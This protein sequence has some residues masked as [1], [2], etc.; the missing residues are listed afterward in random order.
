[1]GRNLRSWWG[2][3]VAMVLAVQPALAGDRKAAAGRE[4]RASAHQVVLPARVAVTADNQVRGGKIDRPGEVAFFPVRALEV[5]LV[6]ASYQASANEARRDKPSD[7][8]PERKSLTFFRLNPKFGDVSVQ[9]VF[10]GVNGA[11]ISVGF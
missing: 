3:S 11:Q 5:R 10:G 7:A 9:P 1:M 2:L 6:R 4:Q 8:R